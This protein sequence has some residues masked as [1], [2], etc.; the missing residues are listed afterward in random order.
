LNITIQ[1]NLQHPRLRR[2]NLKSEK[3]RAPK[4]T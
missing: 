2:P 4:S 3:A 1:K